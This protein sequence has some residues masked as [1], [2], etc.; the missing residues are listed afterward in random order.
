MGL[1]WR[2]AFLGRVNFSMS[3][4]KRCVQ[5]GLGPPWVLWTASVGWHGI[6]E[7]VTGTPWFRWPFWPGA[8][9][10]RVMWYLW[11][12]QD[13]ENQTTFKRCTQYFGH[14]PPI[15]PFPAFKDSPTLAS[16]LTWLS[17]SAQGGADGSNLPGCLLHTSFGF[18]KNLNVWWLEKNLSLWRCNL[19]GT[20]FTH[21]KCTVQGF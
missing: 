21:F 1:R 12:F 7:T 6:D 19:H 13:S 17:P 5:N 3:L 2:T 10:S 4:P 8:L 11:A 16:F 20:A 18:L 15:I 14:Q 9:D